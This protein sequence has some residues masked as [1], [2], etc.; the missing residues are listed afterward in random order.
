MSRGARITRDTHTGQ[1]PA[2]EPSIAQKILISAASVQSAAFAIDPTDFKGTTVI[3]V[4]P[5]KDCYIKMG[6]NPTATTSDFFCPGGILQYFGVE[7]G[8]KI[9]VIQDTTAG[10]LHIM[11]GL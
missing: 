6:D 10:V 1:L 2:I 4:F 11:E 7:P 5:T 8:Q 3:R 9:A